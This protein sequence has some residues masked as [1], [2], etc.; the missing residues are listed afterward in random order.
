MDSEL[1]PVQL[2]EIRFSEWIEAAGLSRSTAYELIKLLA[3]EPTPRRLPGI[4][5]QVSFITAAQAALLEPWAA[6]IKNGATMP[7]VRQQI[8][9]HAPGQSGIIPTVKPG[10]SQIIQQAPGS[11]EIIQALTAALAPPADPLLVPR[12]LTEAAEL[13]CALFT[14]ELATL[15]NLSV[16]TVRKLEDGYSP[17]PGFVLRRLKRDNFIWWNVERS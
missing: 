9:Q 15:L 3:I 7:E 13:G 5:K 10:Q 11:S 2:D 6:A 17:R 12:R 1:V 14:A 4:R 8:T 16:G